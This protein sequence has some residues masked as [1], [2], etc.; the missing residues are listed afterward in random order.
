MTT[1]S[2]TTACPTE[3]L[4]LYH[5]GDL[6]GHETL[7]IETHLQQCSACRAELS[8]LQNLLNKIPTPKPELTKH[9]LSNFNT[10]VMQKLPRRHFFGRPA[11]GL[12]LAGAVVL[13]LTFSLQQRGETPIPQLLKTSQN[14]TAEQE[15][16]NKFE[17][18]Q[19]LDLLENLDLLQQL[20][21]LG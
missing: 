19:N 5:Y 3:L 4:V 11:L 2:R 9:D 6:E 17:M 1:N 21:S 12:G 10:R 16:F 18:L 8:S 7:F 14:F 13:M 15:L 20:D